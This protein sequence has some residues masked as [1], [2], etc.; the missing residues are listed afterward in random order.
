[1]MTSSSKK[2]TFLS[3]LLGVCGLTVACDPTQDHPMEARQHVFRAPEGGWRV[4]AESGG[5]LAAPAGTGGVMAGEVSGTFAIHFVTEQEGW[6]VGNQG[7]VLHTTDG[8][9]SAVRVPFPSSGRLRSVFAVSAMRVYVAGQ[10][11]EGGGASLWESRDAG[12]SWV[13]RFNTVAVYPNRTLTQLDRIHEVLATET[14][15]LLVGGLGDNSAIIWGARGEE[16]SELFN[17]WER[18]AQHQLSGLAATDATLRTFVAVGNEGLVLTSADGGASWTEQASGTKA[19]LHDVACRDGRCVAVG[20]AGTVLLSR[21][22]GA[23]LTSLAVTSAVDFAAVSLGS[24]ADKIW[25]GGTEGTILHSDDGGARFSRQPTERSCFVQALFM[26][27]D[28]F[29]LAGCAST[30]GNSGALLHT[31]TGGR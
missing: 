16:W 13:V 10:D 7:E 17:R 5:A 28:T 6:A 26:V 30:L 19:N 25:I 29:G 20:D 11:T 22:H 15:V 31:V 24:T 8:G 9:N 18:G 27:S 1:M 4:V 23:S 3:A 21:D 2:G 14:S 12:Q